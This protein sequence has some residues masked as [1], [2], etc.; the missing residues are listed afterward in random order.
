MS[1]IFN[2]STVILFT[3]LFITNLSFAEGDNKFKKN[4]FGQKPNKNLP[5]ATIS[6][7]G[8]G[9]PIPAGVSILLVGSLIFWGQKLRKSSTESE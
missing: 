3:L 2:K 7:K 8:T 4:T 9:L 1:K 5:P 6:K